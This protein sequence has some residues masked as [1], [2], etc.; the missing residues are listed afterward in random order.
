MWRGDGGCLFCLAHDGQ[1]MSV[2]ISPTDATPDPASPANL[3]VIKPVPSAGA[4]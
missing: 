1:L 3:H 4:Q 2:P